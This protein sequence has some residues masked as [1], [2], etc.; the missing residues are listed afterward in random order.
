MFVCAFI[1]FMFFDL[2][3]LFIIFILFEIKNSNPAY[4]GL[5]F[6]AGLLFIA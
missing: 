3:S 2:I 4:V 1:V 5:P 6:I